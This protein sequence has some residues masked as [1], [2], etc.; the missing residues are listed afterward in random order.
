MRRQFDDE[1]ERPG[2][3]WR[4]AKGGLAAV[5]LGAGVVV[6]LS[7]YVLPP[8]PEPPAPAEEPAGPVMISG[9]E[10]S[11]TP[12]YS[13]DPAAPGDGDAGAPDPQ[14][15]DAA[16]PEPA[17]LEPVELS[18]PAISVNAAPFDAAPDTPL[19]AVVL[20]NAA[21]APLLHAL[22]FSTGLPLNIGVVAGAGG[23]RET[24]AAARAAGL[25][26]VAEL[27]LTRAGASGGAALEYGLAEAEAASRTLTLMRRLPE[28]VA[29]TPALDAPA[30]PNASVLLG[31]L[32]AL[33]PL[34]FG[35]VEHGLAP[36]QRSAAATGMD[37]FIGVS[38][39]R[40][41]AGASAVEAIAVLDRAAA[42]AV[43][44]GGA[45]VFAA[46]GE[47]VILALQLWGDA[48]AGSLARLAPLSAV[49]GRQRGG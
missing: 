10:V 6:A 40:I 25:E 42:E 44:G 43:A 26:V 14:A 12:A 2:W 17:A 41:P 29:A 8:P 24:A 21:S 16:A 31:M 3:F 38:R 5:V 34:G 37:A 46:P 11:T 49:I 45:V 48:G 22:F 1:D 39:H 9:I 19:V 27:P 47:Q 30:A 32:G 33:T 28:A 35:Y 4:F 23:D 15:P 13:A 7:V 36:E 18:G 20:D